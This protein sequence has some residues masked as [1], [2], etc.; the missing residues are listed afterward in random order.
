M[1]APKFEGLILRAVGGLYFVMTPD[2]VFECSA[3]GI[4]R[5]QCISPCAGDKVVIE[6]NYYNDDHGVIIEIKERKNALA[7]P[8]LANL[9]QIV[10]VIST[11]EPFP[12]LMLLDKFIAI[13]EYKNIEPVIVM[14][15]SD[16][17]MDTLFL[18]NYTNAGFKVFVIDYS[19]KDC[20]DL[21]TTYLKGKISALIGNSGVGK[22]TLLN[23]IDDSLCLET[24]AI[25]RKLGR[26]KHTTRQVSLY[27]LY[28]DGYIADTPGF[29]TL[30]T[31]KY[32]I[33]KKDDIFNCFREFSDYY[34]KCKFKDCSHT[35]EDGCVIIQAV[36]DG[37]IS[38]T[39]YESYCEMYYEA[40]RIKDWEAKRK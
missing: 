19:K 12:N 27:R 17:L 26:G 34:D 1:N 3:R 30:E 15:K 32:D 25:S 21:L 16:L 20:C 8:P 24:D 35:K 39:R 28:N 22:S 9:D 38:K 40:K 36:N 6:T 33:I 18:E 5:R 31:S 13:A 23:Y 4:F 11:C 10:F 37:K 2:K 14:T 7:R 29:S